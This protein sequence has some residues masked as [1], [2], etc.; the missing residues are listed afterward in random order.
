MGQKY[1]VLKPIVYKNPKS[2]LYRTVIQPGDFQL[3]E[4]PHLSEN[5][6]KLLVRIRVLAKASKNDEKRLLEAKRAVQAQQ[7]EKENQQAQQL[8]DDKAKAMAK[9][10]EKLGD[11]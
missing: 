1:I 10:I 4:F 9:M 5:D 2:K 11:K 8:A 7:Q 3:L 6:L